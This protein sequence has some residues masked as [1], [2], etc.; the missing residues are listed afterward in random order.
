ACG[1]KLVNKTGR[2]LEFTGPGMIN[3]R[4]S[5]L[6]GASRITITGGGGRIELEAELGGGRRLMVLVGFVI[7]VALAQAVVFGVRFF[8]SSQPVDWLRALP[9]VVIP[10]VIGTVAAPLGGRFLRQRTTRALDTLLN[11]MAMSGKDT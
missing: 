10:L 3:S 9:A 4:E 6:L 7:A 8:R 11:N 2:S 1:F 5:A